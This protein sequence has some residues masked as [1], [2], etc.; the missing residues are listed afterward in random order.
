MSQSRKMSAVES[1]ATAVV[2]F[3][4]AVSVWEFLGWWLHQLPPVGVVSVMTVQS[5]VL[6]YIMRRMFARKER[7]SDDS[8]VVTGPMLRHQRWRM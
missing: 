2:K 6:G 1:I 8:I 3:C 7:V 4:V 5:V